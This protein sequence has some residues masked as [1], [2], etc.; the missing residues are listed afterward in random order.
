MTTDVRLRLQRSLIEVERS[1]ENPLD[2][3]RLAKSASISRFHFQRQ[4]S[5]LSGVSVAE[6]RR[7]LLLKQAGHKLAYRSAVSVTDIA[8]DAG[9]ENVE[10]FSRA[11]K[12]VFGQSPSAFRSAPDWDIWHEIYQPLTELKGQFM[13]DIM[14]DCESVR[15]VQF[16]ETQ[17]AA[18]EHRGPQSGLAV[19]AQRFIAWRRENGLPPT[20]SATY[21]LLF[22]DPKSTPPED[23]RFDFC[24]EFSGPVAANDF[25]IVRKT[26]PAGRCAVLEHTGSLDFA[27]AVIRSLYRDWLPQSREEPRDF[28]LFVKRLTLFPDVPEHESA[29]EIYL[30]LR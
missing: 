17:V 2:V 6:Y 9:Y 27:E 15:I 5:A 13:P 25:G 1:L 26:I 18:L 19:A 21:N 7:L 3:G 11:F 22:D 14:L 16:P 12:R 30:P 20:K 23:F 8:F 28:P 4:F 24:C 29:C 10:S